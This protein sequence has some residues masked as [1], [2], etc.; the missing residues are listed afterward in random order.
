MVSSRGR[1]W[2]DAD[3]GKYTRDQSD[4][5]TGREQGWMAIHRVRTEN[6]GSASYGGAGAGWGGSTA[7]SR[8]LCCPRARQSATIEAKFRG[9]KLR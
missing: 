3:D 6:A 2:L 1:A 7:R 5:G 8:N 4:K 9:P